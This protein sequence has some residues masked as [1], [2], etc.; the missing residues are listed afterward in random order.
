MIGREVLRPYAEALTGPYV[1]YC[2]TVSR[3]SMAI[4]IETAS[5]FAYVCSTKMARRVLDLGSGFTSFVARCVAE[6]AVSVDDSRE[7]LDKTAGFLARYDTPADGLMMWDDWTADPGAPYDVVI[8][9]F[10]AGEA[11]ESSMWDAA[12]VL[13]PGGVLIFDDAQHEGHR[14]AMF[15]VACDRGLRLVDVKQETEDEVHR[16]ALMAVAA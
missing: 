10:S 9:D 5:L 11:R 7:W 2:R 6:D 13:A 15:E 16:F 14:K 3:R 8:H 1:D 4:S 12:S